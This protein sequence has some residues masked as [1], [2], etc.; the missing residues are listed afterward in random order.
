V[1]YGAELL[2]LLQPATN[3]RMFMT[4]GVGIYQ[5][6]ILN[7]MH[8]ASGFRCIIEK[9]VFRVIALPVTIRRELGLLLLL[10]TRPDRVPFMKKNRSSDI[11][12]LSAKVVHVLLIFSICAASARISMTH[13]ILC[14][15]CS[16]LVAQ[17]SEVANHRRK[18]PASAMNGLKHLRQNE[19]I[20]VS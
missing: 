7:E 15:N 17:Q 16:F 1:T 14:Q 19:L 18:N 5:N 2:L 12:T 4:A 13:D 6:G 3:V 10:L 8:V 9:D 20:D 11:S